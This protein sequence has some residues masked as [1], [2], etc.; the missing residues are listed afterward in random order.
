MDAD[1][2]LI[3]RHIFEALPASGRI[4]IYEATYVGDA[5]TDRARAASAV[6][7][8]FFGGK[9]RTTD[10]IK[11]MLLKQGFVRPSV[12]PTRLPGYQILVAEK[13]AK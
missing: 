13:D 5:A 12:V 9:I 7:H 11:T 8:L 4:L 1:A 3:I 6:Q 2:T 10:Q